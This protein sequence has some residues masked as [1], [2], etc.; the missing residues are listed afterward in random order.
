MKVFL[1][2][3]I[4]LFSLFGC[5]NDRKID[6]DTFSMGTELQQETKDTIQNLDKKSYAGLERIFQDTGVI[7][8]NGKYLMLVFGKNNCTYCEKFKEDIKNSQSLQNQ[9][10]KDFSP[11][12]INISYDKDHL[13]DLG[14]IHQA[15]IKTSQLSNSIYK[16]QVTPTIIFG[17]NS[18]KTIFEIPGYVEQHN[19]SKILEF[20]TSRQWE[21]STNGKERMKLL[22]NYLN[23]E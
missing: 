18:G 3:L 15:N 7:K 9:I 23:K 1:S 2:F 21:N 22:Q 13:F 8:T 10:T 5:K 6:S 12:Y 11:Y 20:I 17:D 4:L 16:I 14:E 19:F